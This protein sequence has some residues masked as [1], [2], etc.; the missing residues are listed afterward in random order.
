MREP[1]A[2]PCSGSNRLDL[3]KTL[4]KKYDDDVEVRDKGASWTSLCT[5]AGIFSDY[6]RSVTPSKSVTDDRFLGEMNE[7]LRLLKDEDHVIDTGI[8]MSS[9]L[10]KPT[11]KGIARAHWLMRSWPRIIW[12]SLINDIRT[13]FVAVVMALLTTLAVSMLNVGGR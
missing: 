1:R 3:F 4:I 11:Y 12:D 8:A 7:V 2:R 13:I 6:T 5:G 10:I 9:Y